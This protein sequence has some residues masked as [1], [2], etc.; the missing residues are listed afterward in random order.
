M[1][2]CFVA[3][4]NIESEIVKVLRELGYETMQVADSSPGAEDEK[5]LRK[6]QHHGCI[7]IT[8]DKDFGELIF[9]Q[10][11]ATA[12]VILIRMPGMAP[13]TKA[14]L[15]KQAIEKQVNK[16]PGSFVVI[17]PQAIRIRTNF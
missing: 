9:R 16:L 4:E 6:A 13:T 8:N 17:S 15:V 5:I 12:G 7:L 2:I 11:R 3:D 14:S 10:K 1:A